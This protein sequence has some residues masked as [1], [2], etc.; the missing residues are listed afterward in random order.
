M[1]TLTQTFDKA[2]AAAKGRRARPPSLVAA[3]HVEALYQRHARQPL[4]QVI[5]RQLGDDTYVMRF[6][7]RRGPCVTVF[8]DPDVVRRFAMQLPLTWPVSVMEHE[9]RAQFWSGAVKRLDAEH[10]RLQAIAI[11][12]YGHTYGPELKSRLAFARQG[13]MDAARAEKLHRAIA[14]EQT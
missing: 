7:P 11:G 14:K 3:P 1:R 12:P 10:A 5:L 9:L 6:T 13:K 8:D 2:L 4:S